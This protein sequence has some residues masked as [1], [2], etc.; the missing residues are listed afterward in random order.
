MVPAWLMIICWAYLKLI[1]RTDKLRLVPSH[2]LF[3]W[4]DVFTFLRN[5]LNFAGLFSHE[6][7]ISQVLE[8]LARK[9]NT[10]ERNGP[11]G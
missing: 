7:K 6:R 2:H 10:L 5:K 3:L 1:V 4:L 9:W 11:H 8:S